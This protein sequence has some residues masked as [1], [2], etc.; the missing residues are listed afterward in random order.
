MLRAVVTATTVVYLLRGMQVVTDLILINRYPE[1]SQGRFFVYSLIALA[2]GLIHLFGTVRLF[3]SGRV[4]ARFQ[5][6]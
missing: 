5:T 3:R 2:A 6:A 4:T 1:R